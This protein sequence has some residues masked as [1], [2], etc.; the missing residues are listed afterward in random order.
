[1]PSIAMQ[2]VIR[3]GDAGYD[4]TKQ[5][6][7]QLNYGQLESLYSRLQNNP[8]IK[9]DGAKALADAGTDKAYESARGA[10]PMLSVEGTVKNSGIGATV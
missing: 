6:A 3:D 9:G 1:M 10:L 2:D 7:Q 4:E 8:L 5:T